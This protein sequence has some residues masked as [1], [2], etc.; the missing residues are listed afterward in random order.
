MS[1]VVRR[2]TNLDRESAIRIVFD[3]LRAFGIEPEPETMDADV[4]RFGGGSDGAYEIV[5]TL[6]GHVCGVSALSPRAGNVG[7]VSKVFVDAGYRRRGAAKALMAD[8]VREGRA[9]G[10]DRLG[11]Q[12]RTVFREAI[13]LYEGSGWT[14]GP[15]PASGP[16]DRTYWLALATPSLR[17]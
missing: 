15:S 2:A 9:R 16:C 14:R 4:M 7:W 3:S 17:P 12:T 11:L 1:L 13:A 8:I 10:Y 5:A 6:D